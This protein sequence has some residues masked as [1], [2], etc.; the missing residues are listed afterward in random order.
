M[1]KKTYVI[2]KGDDVGLSEIDEQKRLGRCL[3]HLEENK[4]VLHAAE[5]RWNMSSK[6]CYCHSTHVKKVKVVE[7][8][9]HRVT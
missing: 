8:L 5:P 1:P 6:G 2:S 4:Y 7:T 9:T 3:D